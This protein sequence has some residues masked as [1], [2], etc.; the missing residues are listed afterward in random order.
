M[1]APPVTPLRPDTLAGRSVLLATA[2]TESR[3][4]PSTEPWTET[5]T[6]AGADSPLATALTRLGA[7]VWPITDAEP[8]PSDQDTSVDLAL[9]EVPPPVGEDP[10]AAA[11]PPTRA[12]HRARATYPALTAR[13]GGLLFLLLP[14][15]G[16]A[17]ATAACEAAT[18]AVRALATTLAQ[19]WAG[20]G[21]RVNC[22]RTAATTPDDAV[23]GIVALLADPAAATVTGQ[24]LDATG[25]PADPATPG[26]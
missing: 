25:A 22:L 13:P 14:A 4:E 6:E 5:L 16:D 7:T 24:F 2:R 3:A 8:P 19:E 21:V 1:T 9:V 10:A 12:F 23:A 11:E 17:A 15:A 20:A 26:E 18:A